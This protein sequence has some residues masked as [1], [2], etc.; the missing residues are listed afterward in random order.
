LCGDIFTNGKFDG[1]IR[2]G[3]SV[4]SKLLAK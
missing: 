2:S 1:A 4:A 3:I